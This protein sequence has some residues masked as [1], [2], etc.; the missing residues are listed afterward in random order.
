MN[1]QKPFLVI[2]R[3]E[4]GLSETAQRVSQLG[5][6]PLLMP[7]MIIQSLPIDFVTIENVQAIIFTSRQSI[8]PMTEQLSIQNIAYQQIP[9]FTVGD[10]TA[11]DALQAGF[12]N[13]IS[14]DQ[15]AVALASLIKKKLNP[16]AGRL[17]FPCAKGQGKLLI[18][19]LKQAGFIISYCEV[20]QTRPVKNLSAAFLQAL[21]ADKINSILF[22]SS[23]TVRFFLELFPENLQGNLKFIQAVGI[24]IKT[25]SI[26]ERV[27]WRSIEIPSYPRTEEMLS[28]IKEHS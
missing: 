21:K 7:V 17:L 25:K 9:V 15:D 13:V 11:K 19:L 16:Q 6:E 27:S 3:P 1:K 20:Y 14:A 4:P 5:W 24:S 23:E 10:I 26:L 28:L 22:F 8:T 12:C 18:A 2:T